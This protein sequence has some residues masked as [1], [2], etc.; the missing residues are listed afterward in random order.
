MPKIE[1][2]NA[3]NI[4]RSENIQKTYSNK[5]N[6]FFFWGGGECMYDINLHSTR[7]LD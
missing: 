1:N 2:T 4:F 7:V 3:L 5:P 6:R